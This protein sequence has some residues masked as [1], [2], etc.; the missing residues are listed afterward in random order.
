MTGPAELLAYLQRRSTPAI[1]TRC[2]KRRL[3]RS[4]RK[5]QRLRRQPTATVLQERLAVVELLHRHI[6]HK[7]DGVHRTT[8]SPTTMLCLRNASL[9]SKST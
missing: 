9:V 1:I 6:R 5:R 7:R 3:L 4:S 8:E 2:S